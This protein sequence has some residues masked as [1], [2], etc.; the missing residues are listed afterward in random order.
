MHVKSLG[1]DYTLRDQLVELVPNDILFPSDTIVDKYGHIGVV[2]GALHHQYLSRLTYDIAVQP[3]NM[4]CYDFS[5]YGNEIFFGKA[6]CTGKCDIIGRPGN[7]TFNINAKVEKGSFVEYNA[8]NP[9]AITGQQ[10]IKWNDRTISKINTQ[11]SAVNDG[12]DDYPSDIRMNIT[13][14]VDPQST[15]RVLMDSRSHDLIT[16]HGSGDL[17]ATYYNKGKFQLFGNYAVSSGTYKM[18]IQNLIQ[19]NFQFQDGSHIVFGGEPYEAA[20]TL[21]A[22]YPINGV[23]LSDLQIGNSFKNNNVHVDC[24]MDITGTPE[25]PVVDFDLDIPTINAD[26]KAM[27]NSLLNS[28]QEKK[29]QV[30]YLLAIGRFYSQQSTAN[31]QQSALNSQ[32]SLAMQS[33]LSGTISQQ[34]NNALQSIINS[35]QSAVNQQWTLGANISPGDE[36]LYNAEYEGLLSGS[37]FNNRLLVNGQFGY[38]D[39]PNSSSNF[40]GDFDVRYLLLPNGNIAVRVYNQTND[41]YFTRSSLNTQGLGMIFKYDFQRIFTRKRK[42]FLKRVGTIKM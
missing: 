24:L 14:T 23:P 18:T 37:L 20:L 42:N 21:K 34:I 28:E 9:D 40:I 15:L 38:R 10:F 16:L 6:F 36:G 39:N 11:W 22:K 2:T 33:F 19:K 26:A 13:A 4:L 1:T 29:Q 17:R 3:Q 7:I 32:A 5:T 41:R 12:W 35:Q 30:L 8:S 31:N 25:Q 27:I